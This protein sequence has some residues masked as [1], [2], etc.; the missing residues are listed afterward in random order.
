[1]SVHEPGGQFADG[2]EELTDDLLRISD[3]DIEVFRAQGGIP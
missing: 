1:M 3:V 2:A